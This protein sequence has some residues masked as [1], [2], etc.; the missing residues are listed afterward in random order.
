MKMHLRTWLRLCAPL[1]AIGLMAALSAPAAAPAAPDKQ[2]TEP[3][4]DQSSSAFTF[5]VPVN[6]VL[7][8]VTVT[9]KAGRPVKDLTVEDFKLFEDGKRQPIQSFEVE[10]S[11]LEAGTNLTGEG[12]A[13]PTPGAQVAAQEPEDRTRLISYFIDDLTAR[14]PRYFFLGRIRVAEVHCRGDGS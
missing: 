5:R 7:V 11:Q 13:P 9:D 14:S 10:S 2:E 12:T 3:A 8:N 4:S 1:P 6:L